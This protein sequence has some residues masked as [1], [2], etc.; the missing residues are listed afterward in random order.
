MVLVNCLI[1]RFVFYDARQIL[2][3]VETQQP[4]HSRLSRLP[5]S[6]LFDVLVASGVLLELKP[7]T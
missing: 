4:N 5:F 6:A 7:G 1:C 3:V 2:Q